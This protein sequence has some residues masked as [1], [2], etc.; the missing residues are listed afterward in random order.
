M[1]RKKNHYI[2]LSN[3]LN[4]RWHY[5][6]ALLIYPTS[7]PSQNQIS[8]FEYSIKILFPHNWRCLQIY[9]V[10]IEKYNH[11]GCNKMQIHLKLNCQL[12]LV[13]TISN[14]TLFDISYLLIVYSH[15][16]R[17]KVYIFFWQSANVLNSNT[18]YDF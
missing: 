16:L 15:I 2:S 18:Y 1:K 11:R 14:E 17:Q 6:W 3:C 10:S 12:D 7:L 4:K 9:L 8:S 13:M 5:I